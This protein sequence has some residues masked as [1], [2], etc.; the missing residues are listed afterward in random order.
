MVALVFVMALSLTVAVGMRH[1]FI[2]ERSAAHERDRSLAFQAAE[3]AG[4]EAIARISTGPMPSLHPRFARGAN[5]DFWRTTSDLVPAGDCAVADPAQRFN[6]DLA[7][8]AASA[9]SAYGN[10][11]APQFIV[12]KMPTVDN[13]SEWECW[14][15]ITTRAAGGSNEA[16]VILQIMTFTTR[17]DASCP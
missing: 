8:C 9:S 4:R 3:S 11:K 7:G 10:H 13:G 1:V 2:G 12:E 15:R 6:W 14:Y 16:D 17:A 5:A